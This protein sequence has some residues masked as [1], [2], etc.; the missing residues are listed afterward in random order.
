VRVSTL[1]EIKKLLDFGA[2]GVLVPDV[3]S[4]Q[5][6]Q[7]AVDLCKYAPLGMRGIST[8]SRSMQYGNLPF[9]EYV[10]RA[11]DTV[12][13]G[14][15][16]ESRKG[17]DNLDEILSSRVWIWWRSAGRIF[18]SRLAARDRPPTRP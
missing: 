12:A 10:K 9:S 11:N 16:I 15:Q 5:Y 4:A 13:L 3:E 2:T 8:T 18:P 7:E 1:Q 14:I 6:A 17:L